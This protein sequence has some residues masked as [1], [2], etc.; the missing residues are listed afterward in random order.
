M[1]GSANDFYRINLATG[2]VID[3][4][5]TGV[6]ETESGGLAADAAGTIF[7]VSNLT[8]Y[9]NLYTY[10]KTTG[11]ATAGPPLFGGGSGA[12]TP[13]PSTTESFLA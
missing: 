9:P 2:A 7:G 13:W 10:D 3:I 8:N 11:Q 6:G 5:P 12:S 4:G 1:S